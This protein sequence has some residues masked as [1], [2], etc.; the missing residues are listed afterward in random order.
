MIIPMKK[1]SFLIY[2]K[3]YLDFLKGLRKVGVLHVIEKE[4][5]VLDDENLTEQYDLIKQYNK[6]I[7]FLNSREAKDKSDA[8]T[9]VDGL[10]ILREIQNIQSE[11]EVNTQHLATIKKEISIIRPWG[12]FSF[13]NIDKLKEHGYHIRFFIC[14]IRKFNSEWKTNYNI[15]EI[16]HLG[17]QTYFILVQEGD[18]IIEIDAEE[19]KLP[20]KPLPVL[21]KRQ[22]EIEKYTITYFR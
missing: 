2:H 6:A 4:S 10:K 12:N 7:K 16:N 15:E 8:G 17:G 13:E 5:G 22:K 11:I 21:L 9:A 14:S 1:Y 18:E 3:E 20:E 19:I